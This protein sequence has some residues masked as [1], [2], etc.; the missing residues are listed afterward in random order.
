MGA[1]LTI[2][3]DVIILVAAVLV[4]IT[5]IYKFFANG[6]K[7]VK[8]KIEEN[9]AE[10][11]QAEK[12]RTRETIAEVNTEQEATRKE[13][14]IKVLREV[15]PGM[16]VDH[17]IKLRE[18]YKADREQYLLDIKEAVVREIQTQL[19]AVDNIQCDM[20]ALAE[21]A[22]D[23]L[24]EKI[25]A[26]YHKNKRSRT[27]EEHEKE[28]LTQYYKDY[29]AIKGNSYID[30]YYS[31]MLQWEVIDDDYDLNSAL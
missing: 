19:N 23:V 10:Q 26:L 1:T 27:M 9:R 5:N 12:M 30:K 11:L 4:A 21:S 24:R 6:G 29:K 8:D 13:E 28:A 17:D 3:C 22:K 14:T 18:K 7:K 31:R 15:L 2:I 16:L 25:M 20:E